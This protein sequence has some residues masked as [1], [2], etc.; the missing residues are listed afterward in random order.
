MTLD[1]ARSYIAMLLALP[2]PENRK[3]AIGCLKSLEPLD[4]KRL[5]SEI[6]HYKRLNIEKV[7]NELT[8]RNLEIDE[9]LKA[10]E[11]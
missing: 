10:V 4:R 8:A 9:I 1:K 6:R 11:G 5:V 3:F 7:I 2:Q